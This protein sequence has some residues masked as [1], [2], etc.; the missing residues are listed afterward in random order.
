MSEAKTIG[1]QR[2]K[3]LES[4]P[5]E[6][7]AERE[8]YWQRSDFKVAKRRTRLKTF[9]ECLDL[10]N[11]LRALGYMCS[12]HRNQTRCNGEQYI[13]HP[14]GMACRCEALVAKQVKARFK[15]GRDTEER[16]RLL[17]TILLHDVVEDTYATL[18]SLP[19]SDE[20]IHSVE[21]VTFKCKN[22]EK[23][24]DMKRRVFYDMLKDKTAVECKGFD[25]WDNSSTMTALPERNIRKN[26]LETNI[27]VLPML[28]E[29]REIYP[30]DTDLLFVLSDAIKTHNRL[31]E[32]FTDVTDG[33]DVNL[34][35]ELTDGS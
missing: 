22:G 14:L 24:S 11:S 1:E 15:E 34:W 10:R 25:R 26:V 3:I 7:R 23:K 21:L 28:K 9:F 30:E 20:I 17:A 18:E 4:L 19:V 33:M 27:F 2:Q 5:A 31:L 6:A 32:H 29:A 12:Q 16:D 8:D 35:A 13:L